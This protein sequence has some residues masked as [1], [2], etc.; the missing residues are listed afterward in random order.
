MNEELPHRSHYNTGL[1][2]PAYPAP[3]RVSKTTPD[4]PLR[5]SRTTSG[6]G[7]RDY[8]AP[9]QTQ[10][11][12]T[13][14]IT[15]T[16]SYQQTSVLPQPVSSY[17]PQS[18]SY[19]YGQ[20]ASNSG[21]Q[22]SPPPLPIPPP[23]PY[24]QSTSNAG[25]QFSPPP[26]PVPPPRVPG[27][28]IAEDIFPVKVSSSSGP[29]GGNPASPSPAVSWQPTQATAATPASAPS[30]QPHILNGHADSSNNKPWAN[31]GMGAKPITSPYQKTAAVPASTR[32]AVTTTP[33]EARTMPSSSAGATSFANGINQSVPGSQ[34]PPP[35]SQGPSAGSY[36]STHS[37]PQLKRKVTIEEV[38]ES[39]MF[40]NQRPPSLPQTHAPTQPSETP[41]HS[42]SVPAAKAQPSEANTPRATPPSKPKDVPA[43]TP[44]RP[45]ITPTQSYPPPAPST[46][47]PTYA[48]AS[49]RP[50][51]S[52]PPMQSS[53][54][55]SYVDALHRS[56]FSAQPRGYPPRPT[57]AST[58]ASIAAAQPVRSA[59]QPLTVA[60]SETL[61]P[62]SKGKQYSTTA[63]A[64]PHP[65][66]LSIA[67]THA[68]IQS[69]R[70]LVGAPA[71]PTR[72]FGQPLSTQSALL[73][74]AARGKQFPSATVAAPQPQS[75][76]TA[77][78]N[79]QSSRPTTSA[80]AAAAQAIGRQQAATSTATAG[81]SHPQNLPTMETHTNPHSSRPIVPPVTIPQGP[82]ARAAATSTVT[83][84]VQDAPIPNDSVR[85]RGFLSSF[86]RN[87]SAAI[88]PLYPAT[89]RQPTL[90]TSNQQSKQPPPPMHSNSHHRTVS[91]PTPKP[92][93][94][95]NA[96]PRPPS[97]RKTSQPLVNPSTTSTQPF[98]TASSQA[99]A[100][101][102]SAKTADSSWASRV[103]V[104]GYPSTPR[105]HLPSAINRALSHES[106]VL[107]TPSSIAPSMP[108][109]P[110]MTFNNSVSHATASPMRQRQA[111]TDSRESKKKSGGFLGGLFRT[112]S[113][114]SRPLESPVIAPSPVKTFIGGAQ[115]S[116]AVVAPPM[117]YSS[118]ARESKEKITATAPPAP[119]AKIQIVHTAPNP[120]TSTSV[121]PKAPAPKVK[122]KAKDPDPAAFPPRPTRDQKPPSSSNVFSPFSFLTSK[123]K[124]T[125]SGA[126]L[127]VCDGNTAVRILLK[128]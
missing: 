62:A 19:G 102:R 119:A 84:Q 122:T 52:A 33:I 32:E 12:H 103:A 10:I 126:S 123:R 2:A 75:L 73:D 92:I 70:P 68:N 106:E 14:P 34:H 108:K 18:S 125:M 67:D 74:A 112:K 7:S 94:T 77:E 20:Y 83:N 39:P 17:V 115:K 44:V 66:N 1:L 5:I 31:E 105:A 60:Q 96:N 80:S 35:Q 27:V 41:I 11:A 99:K 51:Y 45:P 40:T 111:S 59:S 114:S 58:S 93:S 87:A 63:A 110:Q 37:V 30:T 86:S 23:S 118:S 36:P 13:H 54:S 16:A 82:S 21:G 128:S 65:Q 127:D 90:A 46:Q 9:A 76:P 55:S 101:S 85:S 104:S 120:P 26:L 53:F 57:P 50:P 71:Q 100:P 116:P 78:T 61:D 38:P 121:Q 28:D 29:T 3:S 56:T 124:R 98:P 89:H 42:S 64:A 43:H 6:S 25:G 22:F 79:P 109:T 69:S 107:L 48:P 4:S 88:N 95:S 113:G 81:T 72:P 24:G 91:L 97:P 15:S 8:Q 47:H 117:Q 49:S